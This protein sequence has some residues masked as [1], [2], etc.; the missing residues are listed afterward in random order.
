GP[1]SKSSWVRRRRTLRQILFSASP[2]RSTRF[3]TMTRLPSSSSPEDDS[4][5]GDPMVF[6]SFRSPPSAREVVWL[7][8]RTGR[9]S[10]CSLSA[11]LLDE[12]SPHGRSLRGHTYAHNRAQKR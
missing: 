1:E 7:T 6:A 8:S 9:K 12:F 3:G 10:V 4:R 11:V 5:T 2:K